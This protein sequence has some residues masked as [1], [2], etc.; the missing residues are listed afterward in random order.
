MLTI[1][2]INGKVMYNYQEKK[3]SVPYPYTPVLVP[4]SKETNF[5]KMK[6]YESKYYMLE[7]IADQYLEA[8][9]S[10]IDDND[11]Y[12]ISFDPQI[13]KDILE[14]VLKTSQ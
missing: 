12:H 5:S 6:G 3:I 14:W 7:Y 10:F 9:K 11:K 13:K 2:N 4:F 1:K 8:A